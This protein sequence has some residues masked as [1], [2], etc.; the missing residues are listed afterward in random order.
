MPSLQSFAA[1][2]VFVFLFASGSASSAEFSRSDWSNPAQA[3]S[4][5]WIKNRL[6]RAV[7]LDSLYVRTLGFRG[8]GEVAFN[9]GRR[10][11]CF[12]LHGDPRGHWARL[13]PKDRRRIRVRARDS[14]MITGFECGSRLQ[15]GQDAKRAA[16]EFVLD[17]KLVDDRGGRSEVK[18]S[19]LAPSY[20]IKD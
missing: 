5:V 11:V 8:F 16:E 9:A 6:A 4:A 18:I 1:A 12:T 19:Q 14:L 7:T 3:G 20:P 10:R 15:A 2:L 17:L 13:I